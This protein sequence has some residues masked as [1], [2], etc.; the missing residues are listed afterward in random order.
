MN[1]EVVR[2]PRYR[3]IVLG[4]AWLTLVC[5]TWSLFLIPSLA[6]RL[7]PELGLT[8]WQFTL[9][10]I[11][12]PLV[13]IFTAIPGGALGD[14]YGIRRTVAIAAFLGGAIGLARAFTPS[15]GGMLAL[16]LLYGI[17][18]GIMLPNLP[19]LVGIWFPPKQI[20]FAS[21]IY[22]TALGSGSAL[23][24]LT[25]PLFGGWQPAF[26][27]IGIFML[28][29]AVL[30]ALFARS[31]PKGVEI[32]MPPMLSGIK[33]GIRSKNIWF[34]GLGLGLF[35]GT[36]MA[37]SQN[38]P[39]ALQSVH[40]VSPATAGAI[41]SLL[42]WGLV[43][44]NFFIPILSDRVGLRK[45]FIYVGAVTTAVCLFFAWYLA[46]GAA[47]WILIFLG[48]LVFGAVPSILFTFP[49]ELP[50][51]GHEYVGG[52][53]GLVVSFMNAGVL[54]PLLVISPLVA[55][56]TSGAYTTG[57]LVI[58]L[59]LAAIALPAMLLKET[60]ARAKKV[61]VR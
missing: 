57:F 38:L 44:G 3:W 23:G 46:P 60:G 18:Y 30:W 52:A 41:A 59:L 25:G 22:N 32:H 35:L 40:Q 55:A 8:H 12:P 21:G 13:A 61:L 45:P 20:G 6:Y 28:G 9:L 47:T 48:G 50:E 14:R 51:I 11:A 24:L 56:G 54:I 2:Y 29:A 36:L 15:F 53:S 19:K 31:T 16:M 7:I 17:P 43:V 42:T 1:V 10:F 34:V 37:F 39:T 5:L 58:A 26:T 4:M 33:R 49:V 27:F